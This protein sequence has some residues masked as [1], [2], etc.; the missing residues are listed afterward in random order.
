MTGAAERVK[1]EIKGGE[2]VLTAD[3]GHELY[4]G[5]SVAMLVDIDSGVMHE[6]GDPRMVKARWEYVLKKIECG[7]IEAKRLKSCALVE[8]CGGGVTAEELTRCL[9]TKGYAGELVKRYSQ[10]PVVLSKGGQC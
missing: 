3:A 9:T 5:K 1:Y 10:E 7:G 6:H 8:W 4:R 2:F